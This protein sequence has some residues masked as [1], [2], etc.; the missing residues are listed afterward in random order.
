MKLKKI[1]LYILMFAV[2]VATLSCSDD[3]PY[4]PVE[5]P[6][7]TVLVYMVAANDL[8]LHPE[9]DGSYVGYDTLDMKEMER[10]ARA[11]GLGNNRL[12]VFHSTYQGASLL[13]LTQD[14]FITIKKY[15]DAAAVS[16]ARM[17]EVIADVKST[18]AA[19]YGLVLWS[20]ASGWVED[21]MEQPATADGIR[22]LSFGVDQGRRMN[23]TTLAKVLEGKGFDYIYFD[24]CLMGSVEVAYELRDC[25]RY[26]VAS[27]ATLPL[28]GMPYDRNLASL[29]D[30]SREALVQAAQ[31]TFDYY[32]AKTDPFDRSAT[33]TVIDTRGLDGLADATRA[34]YR[35]TDTPH[36]LTTV[37]NYNGNATTR[38]A[39][40]LDFG[41]YVHALADKHGLEPTLAGNF[42]HAMAETVIF[43]KS[44]ERIFDRYEIKNPSGLSTRVFNNIRDFNVR[45]YDRLQ[46]A[47]DVVAHHFNH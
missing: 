6:E 31:N 14:G 43:Q 1:T 22:P 41:E 11:N 45:N 19:S 42:D 38:Q 21:G 23:V 18:G 17:E 33:M 44:T 9:P 27:A 40:Y 15:T 25:A 32:D 2:A 13:E 3:E 26:I 28:E 35:L 39:F 37:T 24:C 34:I 16:S 10:A 20:H 5:K 29:L 46:W 12:L 36:P 47:T 8:G 4:T 30:G 7:R